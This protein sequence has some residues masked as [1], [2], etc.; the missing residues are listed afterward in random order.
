MTKMF[1]NL[2]NSPTLLASIVNRAVGDSEFFCPSTNTQ[3]YVTMS[4]H[5]RAFTVVHLLLWGSPAAVRRPAFHK[6]FRAVSARIV[7]FAVNAIYRVYNTRLCAHIIQKVDERLSP[8][9]ANCY[10]FST[11]NFI[12]T[13]AGA[14]TSIVHFPPGSVLWR[15][16][17]LATISASPGAMATAGNLVALP[18]NRT[19]DYDCFA[20][21]AT[22]HPVRPLPLPFFGNFH[23]GQLAVFIASL[24]FSVWRQLDRIT[25]RHDS[26]PIKLDCDRAESVHNNR[27]GSFYC[28][29]YG[30][31]I[32]HVA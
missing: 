20:T 14:I 2:T 25:R 32:Q 11:I 4:K 27:L 5:G 3:D 13:L 7:S 22:T 15:L 16:F 21:L 17:S 28:I 1:D 8:T 19:A 31:Q 18:K 12:A 26:T 30:R 24:V 29:S 9:F 23:N 10:S 6:A